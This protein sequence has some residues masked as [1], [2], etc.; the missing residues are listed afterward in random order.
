MTRGPQRRLQAPLPGDALLQ[1]RALHEAARAGG[2]RADR[3][4]GACRLRRSSASACSARASSSARTPPTS[5][6]PHRHLR[7]DAHHPADGRAR[8]DHR[9]GRRDLRPGDGPPEVGRLPH[10]RPGRPRHVLPRRQELLRLAHQRRG[11]RDLQGASLAH[12]RWS[13]RSML[14]RQDRRRLL[15]EEEGR[16]GEQGDPRARPRDPRVPGRRRRCASTRSAPPAMSKTW[17]SGSRT[18]LGRHRQGGQVRRAGD[19]RH[20]GLRGAAARGDRRRLRQRRPRHALG[21][22]LGPG[23]VRDLGRLRRREGRRAHEGARH[24]GAAPG[25]RRCSQK[26]RTSFYGQDGAYDT[27]WNV[28]TKASRFV[29]AIDRQITIEG[30]R[31]R[32]QEAVEQRLGHPVGPGRRRPAARVPLQDE[33]HRHRHHRAHAPRRSTSPRPAPGVAWSSAT[34][35]ATSRPAPTSRCCLWACK[36]GQWDSIKKLISDFQQAEPAH[37]L[38]LGAGGDGAVRADPGRRLPRSPWAATRSRRRPSCTWAWSRS[39]WASSPAAAA[40]CSCCATSSGP[41]PATRTS[42]RCPSSRRPSSP[43][44]RPRWP[45]APRRPRRPASSPPTPASR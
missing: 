44:A 15:Q 43:S 6:Q 16:Q 5:R 8:P 3:P 22:R 25:S 31:R 33:L 18:V 14:G 12:R 32:Q 19:A 38:L 30:L 10:R 4:R 35:A 27:F 1:P 42:T 20:A 45:P 28:S 21:L 36:E 40:T 34:T 17:A 7:H 29:P 39:A 37:A 23:P 41:T 24:R 11:A 2:G 13:R 26:G 9:G